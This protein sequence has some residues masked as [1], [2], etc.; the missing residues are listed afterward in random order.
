ML[1]A[2]WP[3]FLSVLL[4]L[5]CILSSSQSFTKKKKTKNPIASPPKH[6]NYTVEVELV[7]FFG[8]SFQLNELIENISKWTLFSNRKCQAWES[9]RTSCTCKVLHNTAPMVAAPGAQTLVVMSW[10]VWRKVVAFWVLAW[11]LLNCSP[12]NQLS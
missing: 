5:F 4:W 6:V 1:W 8:E 12:V 10:K 11:W 3:L 9:L 7:Y 2:C